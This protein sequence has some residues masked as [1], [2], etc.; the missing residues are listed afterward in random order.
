MVWC[1]AASVEAAGRRGW[2]PR[3]RG[4]PC[5][6]EAAVVDGRSYQVRAIGDARRGADGE[7]FRRALYA[8]WA[9]DE[10]RA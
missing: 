10:S 6:D 8:A 2:S 4:V 1:G 7:D 9:A 5:H 3:V